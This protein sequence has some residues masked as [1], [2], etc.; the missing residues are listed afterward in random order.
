MKKQNYLRLLPF[1]I[2]LVLLISCVNKKQI[3]Y[4]QKTSVQPDTIVIANAYVPKIQPGDILSID[5]TSLNSMASSFFNPN[6]SNSSNVDNSLSP[7]SPGIS[8]TQIT[9]NGYLV[10]SIGTI[11]FPLI[12]TVKIGGLTTTAAKEL[13]KTHLKTYLKEP[14]VNVRFLNYKVSVIGEVTKPSVY[15]IQNE[16]ITLPEVISMA[17]DLTIFGKRTNILVVR[18]ING[19]KEFG[20][21]DLTSRSIYVSPYYYLHNNDV[22]YVEP[23]SAKIQQSDPLYKNLPIILSVF[24]VI[25]LAIYYGKH[26]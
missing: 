10:D 15:L 17:G 18:E 9:A 3:V 2:I 21:V 6:V 26:L 5:V 24:S 11:D 22:V 4:F 13:I 1:V 19:K 12:G 8:N 7:L 20:H 25:I 14:T 16:R 23:T